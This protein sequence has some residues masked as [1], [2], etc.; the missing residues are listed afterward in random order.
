MPKKPDV[1]RDTPFYQS[2]LHAGTGGSKPSG[3]FVLFRSSV[4]LPQVQRDFK[5]EFSSATSSSAI[6]LKCV[7][8]RSTGSE[9]DVFKSRR[10]TSGRA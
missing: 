5:A 9:G 7:S 10:V 3:M 1:N 6:S 2:A 8:S 4:Y